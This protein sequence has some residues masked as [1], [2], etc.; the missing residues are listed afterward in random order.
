MRE[1]T[2]FSAL[3]TPCS[4]A[5]GK[6]K[7]VREKKGLHAQAGI[8]LFVFGLPTAAI[9][10]GAS[11]LDPELGEDELHQADPDADGYGDAKQSVHTEPSRLEVEV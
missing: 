2:D 5:A 1:R 8:L 11:A 9:L 4:R 6:Y 10:S 7:Q 3:Q